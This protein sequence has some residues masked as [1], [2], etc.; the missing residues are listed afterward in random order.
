MFKHPSVAHFEYELL[1]FK[2]D[3]FL[4]SAIYNYLRFGFSSTG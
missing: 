3:R 2:N 1:F 4:G